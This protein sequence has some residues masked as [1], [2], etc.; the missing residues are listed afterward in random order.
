MAS[1]AIGALHAWQTQL[2]S[3]HD[4]VFM[5]IFIDYWP[6]CMRNHPLAPVWARHMPRFCQPPRRRSRGGRDE[7]LPNNLCCCFWVRCGAQGDPYDHCAGLEGARCPGWRA[8]AAQPR[9]RASIAPRRRRCLIL[10]F[11]QFSLHVYPFSGQSRQGIMHAV[12]GLMPGSGPRGTPRSSWTPA[13]NSYQ[14]PLQSVPW[15][16]K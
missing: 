7:H 3:V 12:R 5:S 9:G 8:A 15:P 14:L 6:A 13:R 1:G 11:A 2:K 16:A 10:D 4:R